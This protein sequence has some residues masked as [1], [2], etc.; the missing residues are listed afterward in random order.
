MVAGGRPS[1]GRAGSRPD[2]H[3][4]QF[5]LCQ[6]CECVGDLDLT[7]PRKMRAPLGLDG[8][9]E[10]AGIEKLAIGFQHAERAGALSP[11]HG[12]PFD[13]MLIAQ[14]LLV[15]AT[16]DRPFVV[17]GVQLGYVG[18]WRHPTASPSQP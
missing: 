15:L 17:Y 9:V 4:R 14:A 16:A 10:E 8:T 7:R 18:A 1:P 5:G 12:D 13:R 6:C 3:Y 11:L 2:R